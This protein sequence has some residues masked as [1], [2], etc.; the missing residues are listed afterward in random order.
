MT[1]EEPAPQPEYF[2]K[3]IVG[4]RS[5]RRT[6]SFK[7]QSNTTVPSPLYS[8]P[9]RVIIQLREQLVEVVI[10]VAKRERDLRLI[11]RN[12]LLYAINACLSE[13]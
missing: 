3:V 5:H 8:D 9:F 1:Q 13:V 7:V 12:K 11:V 4:G 2:S 6:S 10:L